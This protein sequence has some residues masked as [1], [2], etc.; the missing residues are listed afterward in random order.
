L[1]ETYPLEGFAELKDLSSGSLTRTVG[2]EERSI[3]D[4]KV[5]HVISLRSTSEIYGILVLGNEEKNSLQEGDGRILGLYGELVYS[6]MIEKSF[7]PLPVIESEN[8][9]GFFAS[10]LEAGE[11]YLFKK[12]PA[13]AFEVFTNTVFAGYEGLCVTREFPSKVRS[14]YR[15]QKTP[16]VWLTSEGG[17]GEQTVHSIQELS[18]MIGAFLEKAQK[19]VVLID[20]FEYLITNHG[21]DAFLKFLQILKT[22]LQKR[23]GILVAPVLE[24]TLGARELA[25]I[26]REMQLF[27]RR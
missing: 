15:L 20:G 6:F 27:E 18:I 8:G 13:N 11:M 17:E 23:G 5:I 7:S 26:E 25:L 24:Q 2:D 14:K 22:R 19:P 21:F 9:R 4:A 12:N 16:I 10:S 3:L 1:N